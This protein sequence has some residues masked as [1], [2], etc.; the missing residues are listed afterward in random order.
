[1]VQYSAAQLQIQQRQAEIAYNAGKISKSDYQSYTSRQNQLISEAQARERAASVASHP[2]QST[3]SGLPTQALP[4]EPGSA[5]YNKQGNYVNVGQI[6]EQKTEVTPTDEAKITSTL[7]PVV[8]NVPKPSNVEVALAQREAAIRAETKPEGGTSNAFAGKLAVTSDNKLTTVNKAQITAGLSPEEKQQYNKAI[9]KQNVTRITNLGL[10]LGSAAVAPVLGPSGS[11]IAAGSNVAVSEG[12]NLLVTGK[13]LGTQE[14]F[15]AGAEGILFAGAGGL[16]LRGASAGLGYFGRTTGLSLVSSAGKTL[17]GAG[18]RSVAARSAF[19]FGLGA[20][21]TYVATGDVKSALVSGGAGALMSLGFEAGARGFAKLSGKV[22]VEVTRIAGAEQ[23][24]FKSIGF[25]GEKEIID[26][27]TST[28]LLFRSEKTKV[29]KDYLKWQEDFAK[30]FKPTEI[31]FAGSQKTSYIQR[32]TAG[33]ATPETEIIRGIQGGAEARYPAK[34]FLAA[35]KGEQASLTERFILKEGGEGY[36]LISTGEPGE[37]LIQSTQKGNLLSASERGVYSEA[38]I[39]GQKVKTVRDFTTAK[40][41][42]K[43]DP[44]VY[45]RMLSKAGID[46]EPSFKQM[47]GVAKSQLETISIKEIPVYTDIISVRPLGVSAPKS[48]IVLIRTSPVQ[49]FERRT[50]QLVNTTKQV[51]VIESPKVIAV[52]GEK[53][54]LDSFGAV[55]VQNIVDVGQS[56]IYKPIEIPATTPIEQPITVEQTRQTQTVA[57]SVPSFPVP[58]YNVLMAFPWGAGGGGESSRG[59]VRFGGRFFK[60]KHKIPLPK[61]LYGQVLGKKHPSVLSQ[62]GRRVKGNRKKRRHKKR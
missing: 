52:S 6:I 20:V 54:G 39:L 27:R 25:T 10:V 14:L 7:G 11:L 53:F 61:E 13:P 43:I 22:P 29:S 47:G 48:P 31:E 55:D 62:A 44:K 30:E 8:S 12:A 32:S 35:A 19:M 41:W 40:L 38:G 34:P 59:F 37:V 21:P 57:L 3:S 23:K 16:A 28:E 56:P 49:S 9:E 33:L 58:K 1:M 60:L 45:S 24:E 46:F 4:P 5:A 42:G 2:S 17:V 26:T 18:A 51:S 15:Q 36:R 50:V